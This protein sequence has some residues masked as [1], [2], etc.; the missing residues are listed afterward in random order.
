MSNENGKL[1]CGIQIEKKRGWKMVYVFLTTGHE[2]VEALTVVDLLRRAKVELQTVSITGSKEVTSS[3]GITVKADILFEEGDFTEAQAVILP[4]GPGTSSYLEHQ[5]LCDLV[6]EHYKSGKLLA[7]ICAAPMV[8]ARLGIE[9]YSS[10]YPSM[11]EELTN[12]S[13]QSVTIDGNV[14][15]GEAL[16][17]S[18]EFSLEIIKYLLNE[19]EAE[20]VAKGIVKR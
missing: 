13:G 19:E 9:V 15:T 16:A 17:A 7:A 5:G 14:I 1:L 4:G 6:V 2:T 20:K 10:I 12:Y 18:V 8:L 11:I 3:L